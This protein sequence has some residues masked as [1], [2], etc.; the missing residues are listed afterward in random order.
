MRSDLIFFCN[1][2]TDCSDIYRNWV[3]AYTKI[4]AD[5]V[6]NFLKKA[7]MNSIFNGD[8]NLHRLIMA[9]INKVHREKALEVASHIKDN[10]SVEKFSITPK[11]QISG[12]FI[13]S[14]LLLSTIDRVT[15][16]TRLLKFM[17]QLKDQICNDI[18]YFHRFYETDENCTVDG[19]NLIGILC[20][21]ICRMKA[22]LPEIYAQIAFLR[23]VYGDEV[24]LSFESASYMVTAF[25]AT[26]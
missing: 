17:E 5:K 14:L 18:D 1:F 21:L 9:A 12:Y 3:V 4:R 8:H 19:D 11:M 10:I 25:M 26:L 20:F 22:K 16:P 24:T 7:V 15:N 6:E 23:V 13:Q 2:L